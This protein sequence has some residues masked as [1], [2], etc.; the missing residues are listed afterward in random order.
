VRG[1]QSIRKGLLPSP[2]MHTHPGCSRCINKH[3]NTRIFDVRHIV[4]L[5]LAVCVH[6]VPQMRSSSR[7]RTCLPF[8]YKC[9]HLHAFV[10]LGA[11]SRQSFAPTAQKNA[12]SKQPITLCAAVQNSYDCSNPTDTIR[13]CKTLKMGSNT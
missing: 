4:V 5:P 6:S 9:L 3:V 11:S 10:D 8:N 12:A 13:L 2:Y 7:G 1:V